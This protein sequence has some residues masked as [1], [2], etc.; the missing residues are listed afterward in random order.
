M[1]MHGSDFHTSDI[2]LAAYLLATDHP[3][4]RLE[5]IPGQKSFVFGNVIDAD[6]QAFYAGAPSDARKVLNALRDLKGL[7]AQ[8]ARR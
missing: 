5:G 8:G 3:L 4:R 1:K 6:V 7:L 2:H